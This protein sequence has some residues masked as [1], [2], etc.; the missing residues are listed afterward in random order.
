M[1]INYALVEG[2]RPPIYTAMK[3]WGKKPHNIWGQYIQ[4]YCPKKGRVLDPFAGSGVSAIEAI[5]LKRKVLCFDLNPMTSFFIDMYTS[6]FNEKLFRKHFNL[7]EEKILGDPIYKE[8]FVKNFEN[9]TSTIYNYRWLSGSVDEVV[10]KTNSGKKIR[11]NATAIDKNKGETMKSI[12]IPYWY[13]EQKLPKNPSINDKFIRDIGGDN[14]SNL[15]TRRNLYILSRIFHEILSV[16]N[17]DVKIQLISGLI[18]TLHLTSKMVVPRSTH[19]KRDFSGSWGRADYMV[20]RKSLEQNPLII[21]RRSCIEKQSVISCMKDASVRIPSDLKK[22]FLNDKRKINKK[23]DINYGILDIADLSR[24]VEPKTIDFIITDP[25]YAGLVF[26]M[27][28]SLVWLIWLQH[29]NTKYGSDPTAEITIKTGYFTREQYRLRLN[30]AFTQMHKVLKDDGYLVVTFHHK[31]IQEW[32]DFVNAVKQSGFR[33]DKVTHQYNKRTGESNVSDP[34]GTSGADFYI[35]CVKYREVDFTDDSSRLEY[36]IL[37]KTIE[38]IA[39]RNEPTP[40]TFIVAGL[41][42]EMIQAGYIAPSDYV[43]EIEKILK[44][45]AQ[46]NEVFI[47]QQN[48]ENTSGNL[49]WFRE[50]AKHINYPDLPLSDRVDETVASMLRREIS[51]KLDDV[52]GELYKMYPNGLTPDTRNIVNVLEKHAYRSS[53]YWKIKPSLLHDYTIHSNTISKI[54]KIGKKADF[55]IYVG[56]REQS[57]QYDGGVLKDLSDLQTLD[58][59]RGS[60]NQYQLERLEMID[61]VW[62]SKEKNIKCIFEIENTTGFTSAIQRASN[63]TTSVPKF[64]VIPNEREAELIKIQDP[65]FVNSFRNNNWRYLT[66]RDLEIISTSIRPTVHN[67]VSLS[68]SV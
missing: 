47:I 18:Q 40:Y 67:F 62:L 53:S 44:Q 28:L 48:S 6:K 63:A 2:T 7:I 5:Q 42:P 24:F 68:R 26:Y 50:P 33:F 23:Y 41:I 34:Y 39:Q 43:N 37:Q 14:F 57:E 22:S 4:K 19:S 49:W 3:Y 51:V 21:F 61:I 15:W 9:E 52:I 60:Y 35:R 16:E 36:F 54:C 56:K 17:N 20:R 13:P 66:Y 58:T 25:P 27:D 1:H 32:N 29:F 55:I 31:N 38:I 12:K 46:E 11:T 8:H 10:L 59:I 30:N 65:L 45:H 64:M